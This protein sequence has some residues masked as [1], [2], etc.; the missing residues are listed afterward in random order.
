MSNDYS[1]IEN[2]RTY[3]NVI[4]PPKARRLQLASSEQEN[5]RNGETR[6]ERCLKL[7]QGKIQ[8]CQNVGKPPIRLKARKQT[9]LVQYIENQKGHTP[10]SAGISQVVQGNL[11]PW[12][13]LRLPM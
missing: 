4:L 12:V 8:C 5:G 6:E 11:Y 1:L 3:R 9:E 10:R 13:H 7:H 2:T